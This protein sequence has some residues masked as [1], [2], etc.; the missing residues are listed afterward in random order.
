MAKQGLFSR[1]IIG[2]ENLPD[3][4]PSQLPRTR[5]GLWWDTFKTRLGALCKVNLLLLLFLIP[6]IAVL[7]FSYFQETAYGMA[8]P[9]N[10]NFGVGYYPR[11][12]I[13][14]LYS[15]MKLNVTLTQY[16]LLVPCFMLFG[17]GLAGATYVVRRITWGEGVHIFA[18]F[19]HGIKQNWKYF[20]GGSALLALSFFGMMFCFFGLDMFSS[21]QVLKIIVQVVGVIQ[22]IFI[23]IMFMYFCTQCV[24]YQLRF[25][26]LVKNSFVFAIGLF[27][28]NLLFMALAIFPVIFAFAFADLIWLSVIGW[29]LIVFVGLANMLLVWTV[30]NHYVYDKYINDRVE[31]A[32]KNRNMATKKT[33][34]E[35]IAEQIQYIKTRNTV[36][37]AAYASRK[38][39]SIDKGHTFT[40]LSATYNR[41]DLVKLSEEK[42]VMKNEMEKERMDIEEQITQAYE[43]WQQMQNPKKRKKK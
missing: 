33:K 26:D 18:N 43:E 5:W 19:G 21:S 31:G 20:V 37:G 9:A 39:S 28:Q 36:Y 17:I 41:N 13:N 23:L 12:D 14:S 3:F 15:S 38:L 27:P 22:F 32:I 2:D 8:I 10:A 24:T 4:N 1:L 11:D 6:V 35:E 25:F 40:P 16:L 30:F 34:E 7:L 42:Q 29:I